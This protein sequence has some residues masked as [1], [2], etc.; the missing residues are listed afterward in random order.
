MNNIMVRRGRFTWK[1]GIV[2][3]IIVVFS[4]V[5]SGCV[6]N[7]CSLC[8]SPD[9]CC[10]GKCLNPCPS[11]SFR[12]PEDCL[13]YPDNTERCDCQGFKYCLK[14]GTCCNNTWI[15]CP[16]GQFLGVDCLCYPNNSV[17]KCNCGA[18]TY[19]KVGGKCCK[20]EWILCPSGTFLGEDCGC[21]QKGLIPCN[22]GGLLYCWP[23]GQCCN[24]TW[25]APCPGGYKLSDRCDCIKK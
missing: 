21:W 13:C 2:F 3:F 22:C 6:S 24:N 9:Q 19:C 17:V 5:L 4:A 10:N 20:G 16:K 12:D 15:K 18:S 23:G 14:G 25:Y 7:G 1:V 8:S 11:G